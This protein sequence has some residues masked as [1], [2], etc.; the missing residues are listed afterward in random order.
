M[1]KWFR[2]FG[3]S[4]FSHRLSKEGAGRGYTNTFLGFILALVFLFLSF[5]GGDMLPFGVHYGNSPDY[6]ATLHGVFANADADKR[7]E[8]KIENNRLKVRKQSGEY[9]EGVFVNTLESDIDKQN[10]SI[11][12]CNIVVDTRP[13]DTLAEIEAY[14]VNSDGTN[15]KI[16]YQDYLTLSDV[17]KINYDFKL[18]YT[19]NELVLTDKMVEEYR[20][21]VDGL[22]AE[23]KGKTEKLAAD[24]ADK[25]ITKDE[26]NRAIYE[27]YFVSYYPEIT[28][29]EK[30]SKVPLL[31][32]YYYHQYINEDFNNY[33]FVFDDC[34]TG[35]FETKGGIGVSFYGFYNNLDEGVLIDEGATQAEANA[36]VDN[37]IKNCY[38][39]NWLINAYAYFMNTITLAPFIALML[40][41]A[42]LLA[43]SIMKFLGVESITSLGAILKIVGS[44]VWFSGLVSSAMSVMLSFF[45]NRSFII[46]LPLIL[47]FVTLIIRSIVFVIK[48]RE[49]YK[50]QLEQEESIQTEV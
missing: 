31:R 20:A 23:S 6:R 13:A 27:L 35:S 36:E 22:G 47:F 15:S 11:N 14:C 21:Y 5:V 44:Y 32:N 33:L 40:M 30:T 19:G 2:F 26:Y 24:L 39:A 3:L 46:T 8:G 1:K 12:G 49:L 7:I 25:A 41:V 17:K 38:G 28:S 45:I 29:Y 50:K 16:S 42:T 18:R 43:Y 10:Y 4:F 48:E 34:I 37:F 9:T